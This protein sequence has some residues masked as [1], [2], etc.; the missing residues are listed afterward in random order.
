M[1]KASKL[2]TNFDRPHESGV[3]GMSNFAIRVEV[4]PGKLK[5]IM[6]RLTAAQEEIYRCYD[7]LKWL[8]VLTVRE[9]EN[10]EK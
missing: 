1:T 7:E 4:Q 9:S 6:D 8:G 10:S 3:R 2:K 5:E